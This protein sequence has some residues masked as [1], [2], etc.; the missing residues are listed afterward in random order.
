[1]TYYRPNPETLREEILS[2]ANND[3]QGPIFLTDFYG[4]TLDGSD[5]AEYMEGIGFT[6]E[7]FHDTGRNGLVTLSCGVQI[8]T[9]GCALRK[10]SNWKVEVSIDNSP[11]PVTY[12]VVAR[13]RHDA[14]CQAINMAM[15]EHGVMPEYKFIG[16]YEV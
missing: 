16:T 15:R 1:M 13:T 3:N 4:S 8:S 10:P 6:V 9:N 11:F 12:S 14:E 2:L 7:D 5:V